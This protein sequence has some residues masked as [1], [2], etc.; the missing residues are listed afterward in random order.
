MKCVCDTKPRILEVAI[1][2][3]SNRGY[4]G[5]S[6]RDVAGEVGIS[7]PA[8]Y[9]HFDSKETLYRAAVMAAF[10]KKS[11]RLIAALSECEDHLQC[12]RQFLE[13]LTAG[14]Q[15][16]LH[17]HRLMQ[18]EL[19]DADAGRLAF[20]ESSI[21]GKVRQPLMALLEKLKPGCDALLLS[22]MIF[23]MAGQHYS[24]RP[25]RAHQE[26][27]EERPAAAVVELVL[28]I[29]TPYFEAGQ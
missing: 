8:L 5:V 11:A 10:E 17:F 26:Q 9:N 7:P 24:V 12:L 21:F 25:V 6:M 14:I 1:A 18:R 20:L 19:L 4:N 27:A 16:D 23:C 29:L 28:Q 13:A 3:F 2:L 22:E 15:D